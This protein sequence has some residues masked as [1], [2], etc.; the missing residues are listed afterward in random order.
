MI[1]QVSASNSTWRKLKWVSHFI[2]L[3]FFLGQLL[4]Q[5]H[6]ICYCFASNFP[7]TT[8]AITLYTCT[9]LYN[10]NRICNV[11]RRVEN[12]ES[13]VAQKTGGKHMI[14]QALSS[15][16]TKQKHTVC[17]FSFHRFSR[18]LCFIL[19]LFFTSSSLLLLL[20]LFLSCA[21]MVTSFLQV[22]FFMFFFFLFFVVTKLCV[23]TVFN[24]LSLQFW[25]H[26]PFFWDK[27]DDQLVD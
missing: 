3:F 11:I 9:T 2:E 10:T 24:C 8:T 21:L 15:F 16:Y 4:H 6:A 5:L 7:P 23:F 1:F 26:C 12:R 19:Y 14:K 25:N 13:I 20:L 17:C 22:Y 18:L 27:N